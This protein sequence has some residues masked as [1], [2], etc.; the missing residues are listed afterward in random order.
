LIILEVGEN[1]NMKKLILILLICL[2]LPINAF[3]VTYVNTGP[4]TENTGD[5]G[6]PSGS[7]YYINDVKQVLINKWD[8]TDPPDVDDDIDGG[9]TPGSMWI[10]ITNDEAYECLDN[11]D[12]AAIWEGHTGI[13]WVRAGED[14]EKGEAVYIS[15]ALGASRPIVSLC[16]ADDPAKIRMLGIAITDIGNGTDGFIKTSGQIKG[17][18]TEGVTAANPGD[19]DWTAGDALYVLA[20]GSGGYTN[21]KP[22]TGRVIIAAITQLGDHNTDTLFVI[23]HINPVNLYGAATE[24]I[25]LRL[26]ASDD[27]T[28]ILIKDFANAEVA[29]IDDGGS[30]DFTDLILDTP[31]AVAEGGTGAATLSSDNLSDVASI[32][33][34]DENETVTNVWKFKNEIYQEAYSDFGGTYWG[35]LRARDGDPT[36][37]VQQDDVLGYIQFSGARNETP[38][39]GAGG[40]F[41]GVADETFTST[42]SPMRFEIITT[43]SGTTSPI[44]RF[45]IDNAG[46]IKMGDGAWTNYVNVDAGGVLTFEGTA[47]ITPKETVTVKTGVATLTTAE[48]GTVLVSAAAAY[49]LTLPTASGNTGLTYRFVKTD[50]NYNL[51]TLDGH[52]AETINYENSAGAAQATYPRLN[53]PLAEVTIVSDG[54]NWQV[55]DEAMGQVPECRVYLSANQEDTPAATWLFVEYDTESYDVGSNYDTS[56]WVSGAADGTVADHLQDDTNSQFTATMVGKRVRNTTDSTYAYITAFNDAGDVTLSSDIF[57]DT[58]AYEIMNSKFVAPISGKYEI[59]E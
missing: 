47:S 25:I 35:I 40:G 10:D 34:L 4:T 36:Y 44:L 59:V 16:D 53:T 41:R 39:F 26:G 50:Y 51:I 57:V 21:V 49:T 11:T 3:T 33:M 37:I 23:A 42:S 31:L 30:A 24:D 22:T 56:E 20:D 14:I 32:A 54:T 6:V 13:E 43:P 9:Y 55:I 15:G 2:L 5:V 27:S 48:A 17:V 19:Q 46:N 38:S 29:K 28:G 7:S 1:M 12:G 52:G 58:E 45:A 8:A 18:D